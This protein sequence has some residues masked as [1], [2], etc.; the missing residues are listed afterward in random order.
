MDERQLRNAMRDH[1]NP[2]GIDA[3]D[4]SEEI[5]RGS[6]HDHTRRGGSDQPD[7]DLPLV[8]RGVSKDRV[9]RG[10]GGPLKGAHEI[11][12]VLA[13]LA[14]PDPVLVLDRDDVRTAVVEPP[15]GGHVVAQ[16]VAPYPMPD[17][18]RVGSGFIGRVE[19]HDLAVADGSGKVV[20][21][22]RDSASTRRVRG[23]EGR[24]W[25]GK[26]LR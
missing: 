1:V 2:P 17:L 24:S 11:Q 25:H 3:V 22:R 16:D 7:Q 9:Q 13:I 14:A 12:D 4:A 8:R 6:G 26:C 15:C 21:E 19:R 10:D 20:R 5:R 18:G 23:R